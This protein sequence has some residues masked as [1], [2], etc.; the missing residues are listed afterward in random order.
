MRVS[1]LLLLRRHHLIAP[2]VFYVLQLSVGRR[3]VRQ[4]LEKM[5]WRKKW[6]FPGGTVFVKLVVTWFKAPTMPRN[7]DDLICNFHVTE[8]LKLQI[9]DMLFSHRG[10]FH[11]C[12]IQFLLDLDLFLRFVSQLCFLHLI[13]SLFFFVLSH[14]LRRMNIELKKWRQIIFHFCFSPCQNILFFYQSTIRNVTVKP[15][16]HVSCATSPTHGLKWWQS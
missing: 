7:C 8:L 2:L 13:L 12:P 4:R 5:G 9:S 10:C 1:I 16:I 14:F 3:Y 11:S 15:L 6:E